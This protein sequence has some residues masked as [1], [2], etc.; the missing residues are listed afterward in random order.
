M[1]DL[2][3]AL[4]DLKKNKS[5]DSL[6]HINELYKPEACNITSIFKNKGSKADFNNRGIFSVI[7][8]RS[9][10]ERLI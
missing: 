3:Q 8:F 2:D 5:S 10:L 6:G 7:I 4:K 9:I 1:H